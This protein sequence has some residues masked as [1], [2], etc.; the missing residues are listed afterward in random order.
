MSPPSR[1]LFFACVVS[2]LAA[3][4][5]TPRAGRTP[6]LPP[7]AHPPGATL[8]RAPFAG[9]LAA[10]V[11]RIIDGDTFE[12]RVR[13]WF[14]MEITTLVRIRGFDAAER[15]ARCEAETELAE[16][17]VLLLADFLATGP[18]TLG[19]VGLDKFGGRVLATVYVG[20]AAT[21][22]APPEDIA[23]LMLASGL[24]RPYGGGRRQSWCGLVAVAR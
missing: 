4:P 10:T 24:V 20:D 18:V 19:D 16:Q 5:A 23:A 6:A 2:A 22:A 21:P 17:A 11:T 12:A 15:K 13:V 1:F 3:G 7:D 8:R 9:P 14:G